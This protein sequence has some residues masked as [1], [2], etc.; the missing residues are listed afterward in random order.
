[1]G[2]DIGGVLVDRVAEDSDTSFFG[3]RPM[4]TPEVDGALAAVTTLLA[5]F[6]G[7]VHIVSKAG[8]KIEALSRQWLAH[9]GFT[10]A[11]GVPD[12]NLHFVRERPAKNDVCQRLSIT[13]FVDDRVDVMTHLTA[14]EHRFLFYGGLGANARPL[15]VPDGVIEIEHWG[16]LVALLRG[17]LET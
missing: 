10:G 13:H 17:Q 4:D 9:R 15:G 5:L 16:R 8:P 1:M 6:D 3:D 7:Q 12:T 14:V 11:A 2:I